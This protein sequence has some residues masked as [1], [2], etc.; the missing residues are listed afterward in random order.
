MNC[1]KAKQIDLAS[2]LKKQG[3]KT[4]KTYTKD[5]RHQVINFSSSFI[6]TKK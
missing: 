2:Y 6:Y 1:K 5:I 4:G 3:F